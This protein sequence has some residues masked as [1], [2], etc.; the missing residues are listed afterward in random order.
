MVARPVLRVSDI[1]D[2]AAAHQVELG[3]IERRWRIHVRRQGHGV[4]SSGQ[5]L[6]VDTGSLNRLPGAAA[7]D[8]LLP[9]PQD[10]NQRE[11]VAGVETLLMTQVPLILFCPPVTPVIVTAAPFTSPAVPPGFVI[12]VTGTLLLVPSR[13]C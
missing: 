4:R 1:V 9:F 12:M 11:T 6:H 7:E 13:Y 2:G 3:R 5:L 8:S 10:A